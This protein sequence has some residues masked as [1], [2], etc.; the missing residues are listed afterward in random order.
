MVSNNVDKNDNR[1]NSQISQYLEK[2]EV[3]YARLPFR[4]FVENPF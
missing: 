4:I 1:T 2:L 3:N